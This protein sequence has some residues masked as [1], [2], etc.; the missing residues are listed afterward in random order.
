MA[1]VAISGDFN[2][3][4][5]EKIHK[6]LQAELATLGEEPVV[7][8]TGQEPFI[9]NTVWGEHVQLKDVVPDDWCN[10]PDDLN[11]R[12]PIPDQVNDRGNPIH[13]NFKLK[14]ANGIKTPPGHGYYD[15]K[16]VPNSEPLLATLVDW[17]IKRQEIIARWSAV[18]DKIESFLAECKS[19]NEAVKLWPDIKM[20]FNAQ[21]VARL[22]T[23]HGRSETQSKAA[24]V[25]AGINTDEVMSAAVIARLSGAQV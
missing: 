24:E 11:V 9:T 18:Q 15:T 5:E 6:M 8:C 1:Y 17:A 3:R 13:Y 16:D 2:A 7:H 12:F 4:V 21:D 19:A 25:L 23:K 10:K 22:E 14:F 20:Y